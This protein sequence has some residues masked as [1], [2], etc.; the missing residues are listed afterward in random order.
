MKDFFE[1]T[2]GFYRSFWENNKFLDTNVLEGRGLIE[3]NLLEVEEV[4]SSNII[5]SL[6]HYKNT[7]QRLQIKGETNGSHFKFPEELFNLITNID[8]VEEDIP[9]TEYKATVNI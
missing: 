9:K 5:V 3:N 1:S 2:F 8:C 4:M 6:K 7:N